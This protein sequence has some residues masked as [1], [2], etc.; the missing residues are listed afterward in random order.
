MPTLHRHAYHYNTT[1][2]YEN[3]ICLDYRH[4]DTPFYNVK[5][6]RGCADAATGHRFNRALNLI[7]IGIQQRKH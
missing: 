5:I 6:D 2:T 3:N 1:S 4:T 7:K